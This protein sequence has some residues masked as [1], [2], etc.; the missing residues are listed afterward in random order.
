MMALND[1]RLIV[2]GVGQDR[3]YEQERT[4]GHHEAAVPNRKQ[5]NNGQN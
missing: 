4:A 5:K 3:V 2:R 1:V